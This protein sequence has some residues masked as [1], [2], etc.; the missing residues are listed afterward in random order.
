MI[1]H[2]YAHIVSI[3]T[4]L[5]LPPA[6]PEVRF[7]YFSHPNEK[8][9]IDAFQSIATDILPHWFTEGI[10]QYLAL[11]TAPTVGTRIGI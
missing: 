4:G 5:K 1:T 6:I 8:N 7:G 10:A 3:Q 11:Y 2:E 9:R